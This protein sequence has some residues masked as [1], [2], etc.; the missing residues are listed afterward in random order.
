MNY[1]I[2]NDWDIELESYFKSNMWQK[3]RDFVTR[4][5]Q[6][7]VIFP[8]EKNIFQA[9]KKSSFKETK[10]IILG[11]DP[12]PNKG[13]AHGLAFSVPNGIS[14]PPSLKNIFKELKNDLGEQRER[15]DGDLSSWAEQGVLLLNS[16]LTTEEHK[17][18]SHAGQGWEDFTDTVIKTLSNK[19]DHCVF[20]L[21]GNSARNKKKLIDTTKHCVL[22][23]S[24][25]SPL[26]AYRG[27]FNQHYF[28]KTNNH[29]KQNKK[30]PIHW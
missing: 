4:E 18:Q 23:G 9:L 27:F 10:V 26:S 12:Y 8:E 22:E 1:T 20:I 29:L 19:K 24:H 15:T 30:T 5:Y 11:Q 14:L 17:P 13:Q 7:K 16:V 2:G 3:L 21:W 6:E 25:P 28:S